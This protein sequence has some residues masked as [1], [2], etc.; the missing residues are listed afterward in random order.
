MA[1]SSF[2]HAFQLFNLGRIDAAAWTECREQ[3]W[4]PLK[5][6]DMPHGVDVAVYALAMRHGVEAVKKAKRKAGT[7]TPLEIITRLCAAFEDSADIEAAARDMALEVT[8]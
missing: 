8:P 4:Q 5:A 6:D 2:N 7:G 3:F 1:V